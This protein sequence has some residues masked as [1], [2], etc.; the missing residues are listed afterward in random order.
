[1]NTVLLF[2][3]KMLQPVVVFVWPLEASEFSGSLCLLLHSWKIT[4]LGIFSPSK[5]NGETQ[6]IVHN[7]LLCLPGGV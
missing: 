7:L 6:I 1:M 4:A 2:K 5:Y 3:M